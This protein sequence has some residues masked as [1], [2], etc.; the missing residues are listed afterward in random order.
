MPAHLKDN[1]VT[2]ASLQVAKHKKLEKENEKLKKKVAKQQDEI[3]KLNNEV[4]NLRVLFSMF[5]SMIQPIQLTMPEFTRLRRVD[6]DW[7][8]TPFYTHPQGYK[9]C[10]RVHANGILAGK[11]THVSVYVHLMK[12]E[13]DDHLVWPFRGQINVQLLGGQIQHM[14]DIVFND[15]TPSEYVTRVTSGERASQGWGESQFISHVQAE[16]YLWNDC[17]IFRIS[18]K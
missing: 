13:F 17:L 15:S 5:H 9:L 10:I 11:G 2:H 18:I 16:R 3:S 14:R 7:I 12:G 8:S 6:S 4:E 1:V